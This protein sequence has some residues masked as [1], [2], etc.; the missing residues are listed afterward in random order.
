M[1]VAGVENVFFHVHIQVREFN[2]LLEEGAQQ[3][4]VFT[5]CHTGKVTEHVGL[6]P[7][8]IV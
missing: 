8:N 6:S 3:E 5:L 2:L 4:W 7:T 1:L